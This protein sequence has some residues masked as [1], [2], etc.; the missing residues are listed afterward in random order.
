MKAVVNI[1]VFFWLFSAPSPPRKP[2]KL[3]YRFFFF[4]GLLRRFTRGGMEGRSVAVF[5]WLNLCNEGTLK[6]EKEAQRHHEKAHRITSVKWRNT[7]VLFKN[8][9]GM[10]A[11]RPACSHRVIQH[12]SAVHL[13]HRE[14]TSQHPLHFSTLALC[15]HEDTTMAKKKKKICQFLQHGGFVKHMYSVNM[16]MLNQSGYGTN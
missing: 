1:Q 2:Q 9:R 16:S 5:R 8:Q 10:L 11:K 14:V 6:T 3:P 7:L 15:I 4:T 12:T 13:S